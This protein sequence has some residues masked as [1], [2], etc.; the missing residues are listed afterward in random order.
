MLARSLFVCVS[1]RFLLIVIVLGTFGCSSSTYIRAKVTE[2]PLDRVMQHAQEGWS[3]ERV[4]ANTL[5]LSDAWPIH[6]I[7]ALGYSASHANLFYDTSDSLLNIQYYFQSN[8]LLLLFIPFT[9][10]AE[11]GFAGG[12][13]KPMMNGQIDDIL[14]WS[15]ASV[16]SRRAGDN[17]EPFPP[18]SN[19]SPPPA[20]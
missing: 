3:M 2:N 11:P 8:Q 16:I 13:L 17:S 7:L 15:G 19:A 1:S 20:N 12:A 14:Q 18:K 10:D 4:D 6:S 5:K 9:I